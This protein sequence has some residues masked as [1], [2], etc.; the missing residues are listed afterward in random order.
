VS[1]KRLARMTAR[2]VEPDAI[3]L[4]AD[5][6]TDLEQGEAQR[7]ELV[8]GGGGTGEPAARLRQIS[9]PRCPRESRAQATTRRSRIG[10]YIRG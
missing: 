1:P 7:V 10:V 4:L 9:V 6:A 3:G 5:A 2:E 8:D